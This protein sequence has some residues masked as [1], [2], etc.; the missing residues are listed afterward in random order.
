MGIIDLL[1]SYVGKTIVL[2]SE[3]SQGHERIGEDLNDVVFLYVGKD[4]LADVLV[5][6]FGAS[7]PSLFVVDVE[8]DKATICKLKDDM[9]V[10]DCI[11]IE[12]AKDQ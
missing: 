9:A 3:S 10:E 11:E 1:K 5:D 7:P 4:D 6:E 2:S 12:E 8:G